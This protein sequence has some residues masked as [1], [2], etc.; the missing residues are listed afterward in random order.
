[1]FE[2]WGAGMTATRVPLTTPPP[3]PAVFMPLS[4]RLNGARASAAPVTPIDPAAIEAA[5]FAAGFDEG[6]RTVEL[7]LAGE[8]AALGQLAGALEAMQ[9]ECSAAL[10]SLL[11]AT[12]SRLV[13]QIVGEVAIDDALLGE[14]A[15]RCAALIAEDSAPARMRLNPA[16]AER[17]GAATL[18]VAMIADAGIAPG[19]VVLET[20]DGWIEDGAETALEKLGLALDRMGAP[21]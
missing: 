16:D 10:A 8:R 17:L 1:M 13:R 6:R 3:P 4:A 9:P 2:A 15:A 19:M 18:P 14:R 20:A 7:E 12:V 21:R 11:S 5:A